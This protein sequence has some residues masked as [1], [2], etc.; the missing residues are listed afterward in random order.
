[1][2]LTKQLTDEKDKIVG[3]PQPFNPALFMQQPSANQ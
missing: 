3:T 2:V 1:M